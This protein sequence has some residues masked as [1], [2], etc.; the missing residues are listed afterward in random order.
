MKK[1]L[2]IYLKI[3]VA[4]CYGP[5]LNAQ[6][7]TDVSLIASKS[8]ICYGDPEALLSL[9]NTLPGDVLTLEKNGNTL[10]T[11]NIGTYSVYP[12]PSGAGIYRVK[13][14]RGSCVHYTNSITL[15]YLK[16]FPEVFGS[17][18]LCEGNSN[19]ITINFNSTGSTAPASYT[20]QEIKWYKDWVEI[21]NN[22]TTI[23][24]N[25]I[26]T[27][28]A[29]SKF[30][31]CSSTYGSGSIVQV[32]AIKPVAKNLDISV[33]G[34]YC[35]NEPYVLLSAIATNSGLYYYP[36]G[37]GLGYDLQSGYFYTW[38][39]NGQEI[40]SGNQTGLYST[41]A[42]S[43]SGTY[44]LRLKNL[45]LCE[46]E[47]SREVIISSVKCNQTITFG[48]LSS[49]TYGDASFS[50]NATASSG[51]PVTYTSSNSS[52]ATVSGNTV[53]ITGAGSTTITASQTGNI[54]FFAAP[55]V[56]QTLT[57]TKAMLTATASSPYR[58]YAAANPI[59]TIS[60]AGFVNGEIASVIDTAP[61]AS[62]TATLTSNT[63][64]YPITVSGGS[65]NNYA[66]TYVSGTLTVNKATLQV[67]ADNKSRTYGATNP[68][69][70]FSYAGF[71]N[72]ETVAVIDTPPTGTTAAGAS[73]N[74]GTYAI[75]PSGGTD[76]NYTFNYVN[77]T[78]T[79][80][81]ATIQ[82]TANASR[83][84]NTSNPAFSITYTGLL[85]GETGSVID[86]PPTA[87][88]TATTSSPVGSYPITLSGGTDNNYS[89]T[90]ISGTLTI[91]KANQTV[92]FSPIP[93][94]C[95]T[96]A[97]SLAASSSSGL[98]VVFSS[99]NTAIAT[100]SGSTANAL[101]TGTVTITAS[102]PG[103]ANYNAASATQSLVIASL[104]A[105]PGI[106]QIGCVCEQYVTLQASGGS[107]YV[108]STGYVGQTVN[109][110]TSADYYVTSTNANGCSRQSNLFTAIIPSCASDPC[111]IGPQ[112]RV[113]NN[114]EVEQTELLVT[115]ATLYPNPADATLT[116]HLPEPVNQ[117]VTIS[118][119]SQYGQEV[120]SA[121]IVK[122]DY[123]IEFDTKFLSKGMYVLTLR[124][125][126]GNININRKVMINH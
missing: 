121:V 115:E 17:S 39:L 72:G 47:I 78:L 34:P 64:T 79:V 70:T 85:N 87:T 83:P 74:V 94:K 67:T 95:G 109:M 76:N 61:T 32:T 2:V 37:G 22:T 52:V 6:C 21:A 90:R 77:G 122:G 25:Q 91:T 124:T 62:T 23:N 123:K 9:L 82:A 97:V 107:N 93:T 112:S 5:K 88:T 101:Q 3:L 126:S 57:V 46:Q 24:G 89:I 40:Y 73:S 66:F 75:T 29:T 53:T 118:L 18:T 10:A 100:I 111:G 55:S 86:T 105:K 54:D 48:A 125:T 15:S 106:T 26:G 69:F 84:Y 4:I 99:A 50:L 98:T 81:K 8:V 113:S 68:T 1:S 19:P 27:Y 96:G 44:K 49:K 60:Y 102:Q 58:T 119:Y 116:V 108:W 114:T 71:M 16:V 38:Y 63:G 80:S 92:T 41:I 11:L 14:I 20:P 120:K 59:F 12:S 33:S 104:P 110:V 35:N 28:S 103:N 51:L 45:F 65:D 31:E 36:S 117:N 43:Q 30:A 42:V 13:V 56:P 7:P